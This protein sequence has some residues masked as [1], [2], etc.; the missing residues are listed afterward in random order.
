M[1]HT[2]DGEKNTKA[3]C[4]HPSLITEE[5]WRHTFLIFI[6]DSRIPMFK[7]NLPQDGVSPKIRL[8]IEFQRLEVSFGL[9][10]SMHTKS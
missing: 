9:S 5:M 4:M 8:K 7:I 10:S 1:V 6:L 2:E 3:W